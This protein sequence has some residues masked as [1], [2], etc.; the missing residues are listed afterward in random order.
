[1]KRI[2]LTQGKVALIDDVDYEFL[3]QWKWHYSQRYA[4]RS[5][6]IKNI[7]HLILMHREIAKRMGVGIKGRNI[8]HIDMNSVNNCQSNLRIATKSQNAANRNKPRNNKSGYKGVFWRPDKNKWRADI[9]INYHRIFLGYF[10]NKIDAA[11]AYNKAAIK[12]FGP[13][14]RVNKL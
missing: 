11:K 12:Y 1:M 9:R 6:R 10:N 2:P 5:Q 8:D 4:A 13:F 14:A 7:K 3:N